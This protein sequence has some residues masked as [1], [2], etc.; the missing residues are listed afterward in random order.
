MAH[1]DAGNAPKARDALEAARALEPQNYLGRVLW[2][3]LLAV[4]GRRADA[5]QAMDAEVLSTA[6]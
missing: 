2:A 6:S 5:M 3:L 1:L 4:E